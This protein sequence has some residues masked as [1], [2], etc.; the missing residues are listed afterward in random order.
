M[1]FFF[2]FIRA[3]DLLLV[4][5]ND[6]ALNTSIIFCCPLSMP[7]VST[8]FISL[9]RGG[10]GEEKTSPNLLGKLHQDLTFC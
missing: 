10:G 1:T 7:S 6:Q 9:I 4:L 2:F 5:C 3:E 8:G